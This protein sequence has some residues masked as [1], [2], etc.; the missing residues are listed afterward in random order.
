[1]GAYLQVVGAVLTAVF[2]GLALQKQGKEMTMVL[3]IGVCV[4]VLVVMLSYLSPVLDFAETL[5]SMGGLNNDIISTILKAVG[6]GLVAEIAETLCADSGNA[7]MGKTIQILS[8][9]IILWLSL[10]V[11]KTLLELV[12]QILE[13]AG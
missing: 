2:L 10:P 3:S 6:I 1:M 8:A 9:S 11:M 12:G 5:R 13:G 4:M 7:A